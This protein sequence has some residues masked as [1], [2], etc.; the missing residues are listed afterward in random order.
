MVLFLGYVLLFRLCVKSFYS[1]FMICFHN[2]IFFTN[3]L[4][5]NW[6]RRVFPLGYHSYLP[7][8]LYAGI[9]EKQ[10]REIELLTL[11]TQPLKTLQLFGLAV[12][13]CLQRP[14]RYASRK[15]G[16]FVFAGVL[17]GV[18]LVVMDSWAHGEVLL[19]FCI[20]LCM[21][22]HICAISLFI[23]LQW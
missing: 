6:K 7:P 2:F 17:G 16:W 21:S 18:V 5:S 11:T 15:C 1:L 13:Q 4:D 10:Q 20:Y 22:T 19:I 14:M 3:P 8:Y 12:L 23:K 9:R